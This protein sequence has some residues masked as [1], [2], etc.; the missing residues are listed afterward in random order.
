MK[1]TAFLFFTALLSCAIISCGNPAAE[2]SKN[3]SAKNDSVI[4]GKKEFILEDILN[5]PNE[6]ALIEKFGKEHVS[7]DTIWGAEGEF[8]MGSYINKGKDDEVQISWQNTDTHSGIS[9]VSVRAGYNYDTGKSSYANPWRSRTGIYMGM[10]IRELEKLN[11]QPFVF[12]GFDWDYGGGVSF[13]EGKLA[14]QHVGVTLGH[15][16]DESQLTPEEA[17]AIIG[18]R[19]IHSDDPAVK[20]AQPVVVQINV[21]R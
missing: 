7:Y 12:S 10:P 18:D 6:K 5:V 11:G 2:N 14:G 16:D 21:W 1:Q 15:A 9:V 8:I 17:D 4:T 13:D 3:D 19:D 20:K